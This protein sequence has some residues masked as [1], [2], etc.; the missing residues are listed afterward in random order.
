MGEKPR[1]LFSHRTLTFADRRRR[2]AHGECAERERSGVAR[3]RPRDAVETVRDIGAV[4]DCVTALGA[5][6]DSRALADVPADRRQRVVIAA[7]TA[8]SIAAAAVASNHVGELGVDL[9]ELHRGFRVGTRT[10]ELAAQQ[11]VFASLRGI[12]RPLHEDRA[13][14]GDRAR[15]SHGLRGGGRWCHNEEACD[16]GEHVAYA[17]AAVRSAYNHAEHVAYAWSTVRN[18]PSTRG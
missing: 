10:Y 16:S 18:S 15:A 4:R 6:D 11:V 3:D 1:P 12:E 13:R 8:H 2:T 17:L 9:R 5:T 7:D 14:T